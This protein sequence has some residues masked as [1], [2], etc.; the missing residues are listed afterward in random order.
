MRGVQAQEK[1]ALDKARAAADAANR[2]QEEKTALQKRLE[3]EV[4]SARS[5]LEDAQQREQLRSELST[6]HSELSLLRE[7]HTADLAR[8][9]RSVESLVSQ[10]VNEMFS[11]IT[12]L[13]QR[14]AEP[15]AACAARCDTLTS[16]LSKLRL[17][18]DR[19]RASQARGSL[20]ATAAAE[21]VA[22]ARQEGDRKLQAAERAFQDRLREKDAEVFQL[23]QRLAAAAVR[24]DPGQE[25]ARRQLEALQHQIA[26]LE[27]DLRASRAE[28][29]AA[30]VTVNG[31]RAQLREETARPS[32]VPRQDWDEPA[33][34]DGDDAEPVSASQ[35]ASLAV[36]KVR[37][38]RCAARSRVLRACPTADAQSPFPSPLPQQTFS[39]KKLQRTEGGGFS[40]HRANRSAPAWMGLTTADLL[41]SNEPAEESVPE[42]RELDA[43]REPVAEQVRQHI[44]DL[45]RVVLA[46]QLSLRVRGPLAR[47]CRD[48]FAHAAC[49]P[50]PRRSKRTG[51]GASAPT[52][53]ATRR[54]RASASGCCRRSSGERALRTLQ[55][56]Q[57][58]SLT[59]G[60]RS[61]NAATE[62]LNEDVRQLRH[63]Q[64]CVARPAPPFGTP[65]R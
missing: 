43:Y 65:G 38:R 28:A 27:A 37:C 32:S 21:E 64:Q 53:A 62:Q 40:A 25:E 61:L 56:A 12:R 22:N 16:Q 36:P 50:T 17:Q 30:Q 47:P 57:A 35:R 34:A 13:Q 20:S 48:L 41:P 26:Q 39:G 7:R 8:M 60:A 9:R 55:R 31:L 2:A 45:K 24:V 6:A 18:L 49:P 14:V 10:K 33:R 15:V 44:S 3:A 42:R 19:R 29:G 54:W 4:K 59:C 51:S 1:Q 5:G 52:R 23:Q 11:G 46:M 58:G 63:I